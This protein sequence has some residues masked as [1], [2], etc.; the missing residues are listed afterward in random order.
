MTEPISL[1]DGDYMAVVD[2]IEDGL[3]TVFFK[4]H[5][6]EVAATLFSKPPTSRTMLNT[7]TPCL[8]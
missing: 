6:D 7:R 2:T 3:A 4:Q 1:A 5:G 8:T